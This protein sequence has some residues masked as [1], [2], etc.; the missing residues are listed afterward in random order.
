MANFDDV[1]R[2][3]LGL[4]DTERVKDT[5][6]VN[7]RNFVAVYPEKIDPKKARV[8]NYGAI[9]VWIADLDEKAA[10]LQ[11]DPTKFFTTDHYNGYPAV[12]VWLDGL[13]DEE[14]TQL[15]TEAWTIRA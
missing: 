2:I 5:F 12:L 15:L 9:L 1:V 13:G 7:G 8:P 3:A 6:K 11:S 10:Y 14:L 4:P